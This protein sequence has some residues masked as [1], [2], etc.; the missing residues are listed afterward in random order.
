M[1]EEAPLRHGLAFEMVDIFL[2]IASF[3]EQSGHII[4]LIRSLIGKLNYLLTGKQ[5]IVYLRKER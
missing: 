1:L 2:Q 5:C 4:L 3:L